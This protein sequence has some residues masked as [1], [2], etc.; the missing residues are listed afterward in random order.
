MEF[1]IGEVNLDFFIEVDFELD[2]VFLSFGF[3]VFVEEYKMRE[4]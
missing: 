1:V 3:F 2:I 4:F